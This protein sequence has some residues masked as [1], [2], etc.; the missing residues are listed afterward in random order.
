MLFLSLQ[1]R[2]PEDLALGRLVC[3]C[4]VQS[5]SL[6]CVQGLPSI[7]DTRKPG[8]NRT[9]QQAWQTCCKILRVMLMTLCHGLQM[10]MWATVRGEADY[11][12]IL[13]A[14]HQL[15]CLALPG[16]AT[17]EVLQSYG[18]HEERWML[19]KH[20]VS[21]GITTNAIV[22]EQLGRSVP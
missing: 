3:L 12:H 6:M 8:S 2:Q 18:G 16:A 15:S 1:A 20:F 21:N 9:V 17:L 4:R 13:H 7:E 10:S 19:T 22:F 14:W 5:S 11:S